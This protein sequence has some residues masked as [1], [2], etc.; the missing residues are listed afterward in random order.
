[1]A[2]GGLV[3]GLGP[4]PRQAGASPREPA[5]VAD[6]AALQSF[7]TPVEWQ[8]LA[9]AALAPSGHNAQ[10]WVVE[11]LE[12][13]HWRVGTDRRRWL[14]AV[15]PA[16]REATLSIGTFLEN[17]VIA[18]GNRGLAVE[19]GV[20]AAATTDSPLLEIRLGRG[21][22]SGYP[23]ARLETRRT[24]RTGHSNDLIRAADLRAVTEGSPAFAYFPRDTR[25]ARYLAEGTIEANRRQA[26]RDPAQEELADWI[27]WSRQDQAR[28]RNGL[29]PES[30]EIPGLARWYVSTFFD[31]RSVL[32]RSFRETGVEQVIER[33]A[34]G[35]GWLVLTGAPDVASLIETGRQCQ[36]MWLRL[37]ER[38]L[39]IH[40]MTQLL[41]ESPQVDGVRREL[42]LDATPQF[43][44]RIGYVARY[45]APVSPRMPV[46]WFTRR[47][48][49]G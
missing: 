28:H 27:R 19:Y 25:P 37:R 47:V 20:L 31:R 8:V 30:M 33:V 42:G 36:R 23:L 11:I 24:V 44:L 10:P 22:P 29:T 46:S 14:P 15:D 26:F 9:H 18:A 12:P 49:P 17:L 38:G 4:V 43:I 13:G 21:K 34:E 41:E 3:L 6:A 16:N 48:V 2:T 32:K 35:G 7:L 45:P 40:P 5:D 39:A 1:V